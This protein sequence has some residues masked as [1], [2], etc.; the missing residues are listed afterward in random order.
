MTLAQHAFIDSLPIGLKTS[1]SGFDWMRGRGT[2]KYLHKLCYRNALPDSITQRKKQ[3]GFVPL[4]V[5]F[6]NGASNQFILDEISQSELVGDLL[7]NKPET[8]I[9]IK[10][11]LQKPSKWFWGQQSDY[12]R[13]FNLMI[14]ATWDRLYIRGENARDLT[15]EWEEIL[16]E[17]SEQAHN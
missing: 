3:G 4:S 9:Q 13:L 17:A 5:F 6:R 14:L 11:T 15:A 12:F 2:S 10:D 1:G 16:G 7:G 8:L